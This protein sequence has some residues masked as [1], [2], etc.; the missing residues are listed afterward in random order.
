[1]ASGGAG[2]GE[3]LGR[4]RK[5]EQALVVLERAVRAVGIAATHDLVRYQVGSETLRHARG[6]ET[7]VVGFVEESRV[8][9]WNASGANQIV[10]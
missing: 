3:R 6:I 7:S 10:I 4:N 1:M 8:S 9:R 2:V 5:T